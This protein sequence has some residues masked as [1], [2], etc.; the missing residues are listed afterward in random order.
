METLLTPTPDTIK[1]VYDE[2]KAKEIYVE[3]HKI[4]AIEVI[5]R[6]V[7]PV[8]LRRV[9]HQSVMCHRISMM[10]IVCCMM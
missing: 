5:I 7:G 3:G 10:F 1:K 6:R 4:V 2:A 8:Q 9:S